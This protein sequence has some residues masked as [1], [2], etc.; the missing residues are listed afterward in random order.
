MRRDVFQA[1]ADPTRREIINMIAHRSLNVNAVADNFDV[2]RTAIYKH[3]KI[4][5]ECGLVDM[6]QQGRERYCEAKLEKL[7]EVSD[8][9]EQYRQLWTARFDA[10]ENYLAVLQK[11]SLSQ[12]KKKK[13]GRN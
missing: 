11:Q 7:S 6:K 8:W 3:I 5:I 13:N 10:L 4:L 2:S 1:I 12:N 9:V